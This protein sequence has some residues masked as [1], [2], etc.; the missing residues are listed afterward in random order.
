[1]RIILNTAKKAY[2]EDRYKS[3]I[4]TK[5]LVL[6]KIINGEFRWLERAIWSRRPKLDYPVWLL[7]SRRYYW[8]D[9]DWVSDGYIEEETWRK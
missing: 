5:Y 2:K 8:E 9:I 4:V 1:M 7:E 3:H 6:P